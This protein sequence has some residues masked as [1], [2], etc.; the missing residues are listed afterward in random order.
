MDLDV[1]LDGLSVARSAR[2]LKWDVAEGELPMWVADMDFPPP[3]AVRR[4]V[5]EVAAEARF[6]YASTIPRPLGEALSGWYARRHDTVIDPSWVLFSPGV[7]L[8]IGSV[9][10]TL[11]AP[12]DEVVTLTPNYHHFFHTITTN[13]RVLA[14]SEMIFADGR[15]QIDWEDLEARLAS[16]R[17]TA[18]LVC[19]PHNPTGQLWDAP[20]LRRFGEIAAACGAFVICDEIHGDLTD[21]GARH[22]PWLRVFAG[23]GAVGGG[24]AGGA[25]AESAAGGV[26]GGLA[27]NRADSGAGEP[28]GGA[29]GVV[30]AT[31]TSKPFNIA[32]LHSA[33]LVIPDPIQRARVAAGLSRDDLAEPNSFAIPA[34]VAAYAEGGPWLDA[35]RAYVAANR[36]FAVDELARLAPEARPVES[37]AT[38]LMWID[39]RAWTHDSAGF[40]RRL[41]RATGLVIDPG[42][43]FGPGGEGFA[44]L[45]LAAPRSRVA[46]GIGR[47]VR[48]LEAEATA[49]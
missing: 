18:F 13:G 20:T 28:V 40:A 1:D 5:A 26:A 4:A 16:P 42:V 17:A 32:G 37:R 23:G 43:R 35:V 2:T 46:D 30:M 44:R 8:G 38:Y 33:A 45:N 7:N 31:S 27:G 39:V 29:A 3:E 25:S 41:R 19:N 22:N 48:G 36:A 34:A 6:G 12:G 9:L 15:H 21:P 14:A 47:L 10:R 49:G 24:S 11:T